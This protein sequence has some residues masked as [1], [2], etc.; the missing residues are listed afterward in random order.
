MGKTSYWGQNF[1]QDSWAIFTGIQ[2]GGQRDNL[3]YSRTDFKHEP[4]IRVLTLCMNKGNRQ[5]RQGQTYF[6][7]EAT[8]QET[9]KFLCYKNL[10]LPGKR[11]ATAARLSDLHMG[12]CPSRQ[13]GVNVVASSVPH[14]LALRPD[15]LVAGASDRNS[16]H[17][18]HAGA[19]TEGR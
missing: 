11:D 1:Q 7:R 12:I 10:H 9:L 19:T 6:N 17:G 2:Q 4:S 13:A 3:E 18:V 16:P 15:P 8:S 14:V 5:R